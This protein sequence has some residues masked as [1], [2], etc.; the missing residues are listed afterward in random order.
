MAE[1]PQ[2]TTIPVLAGRCRP[3][4]GAVLFSILTWSFPKRDDCWV[5]I[6]LALLH[7]DRVSARSAITF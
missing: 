4:A 7:R 2:S 6:G 1:Y 3:G 5:E